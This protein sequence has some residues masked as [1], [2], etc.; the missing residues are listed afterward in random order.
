MLAAAL[1]AVR[2]EW[3][4]PEVG[5]DV[6]DLYLEP[7]FTIAEQELASV[8]PGSGAAPPVQQVIVGTVVFEQALVALRPRQ[9]TTAGAVRS[10][11]PAPD[12]AYV[13][14]GCAFSNLEFGTDF[15]AIR[16]VVQAS[17]MCT[18]FAAISVNDHV[19]GG[20]PDRAGG[21]RSTPTRPP[22]TSRWCCWAS[23]APSP[24]GSG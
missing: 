9:G 16:D 15:G 1:D 5:P 8:E 20:H 17:T 23:S 21:E 14:L 22:C 24:P 13:K 12:R 7:A 10:R 4:S 19:V 2:A 6:F 18:G 3:S 11:R